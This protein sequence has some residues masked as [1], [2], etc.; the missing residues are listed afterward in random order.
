MLRG[1]VVM[2]SQVPTGPNGLQA[3]RFRTV[4]EEL[5]MPWANPVD[6]NFHEVRGEGE[7]AHSKLADRICPRGNLDRG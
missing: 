5:D 2:C 6:V 1:C 3:Y 7:R 4:F